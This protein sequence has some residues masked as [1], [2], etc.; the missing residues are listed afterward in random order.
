[1][2]SDQTI[3]TLSDGYNAKLS[4]LVEDLASAS[5][6]QLFPNPS[7][8]GLVYFNNLLSETNYTDIKVSVFSTLGKLI[9]KEVIKQDEKNVFTIPVDKLNNGFYL[10]EV[11]VPDQPVFFQKLIINK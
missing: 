2:K 3:C 6:I 1:M 11:E 8:N 5:S 10:F 9:S 4:I 7:M